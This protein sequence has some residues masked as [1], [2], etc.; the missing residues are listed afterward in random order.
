MWRFDRTP[1][2]GADIEVDWIVR[3]GVTGVILASRD[4]RVTEPASGTG[5]NGAVTTED[6]V[7]AMSRAVGRLGEQI[8]AA[9]EDVRAGR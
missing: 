8:A 1:E 4:A 9:I 5:A 6:T 7:S 3:D 2:G